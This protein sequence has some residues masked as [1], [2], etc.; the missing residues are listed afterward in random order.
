MSWAKRQ[1]C[2]VT[3]H[4]E[5]LGPEKGAVAKVHLE[6]VNLETSTGCIC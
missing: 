2:N 5:C 3:I 4:S 1:A 6:S